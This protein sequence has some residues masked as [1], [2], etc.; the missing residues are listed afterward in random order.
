MNLLSLDDI[1][2]MYRVSRWHARDVITKMPGFPLPVPGSTPRKQMWLQS[3]IEAF[4]R[5]KPANIPQAANKSLISK[6][7]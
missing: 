1:A 4:L 3:D 5:R 6:A 7:A 2:A